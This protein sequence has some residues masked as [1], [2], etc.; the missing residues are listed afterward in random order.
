MITFWL[1]KD[2]NT[3]IDTNDPAEQVDRSK[4]LYETY[5]KLSLVNI[6]VSETCSQHRTQTWEEDVHEKA[7]VGRYITQCG[8]I[9]H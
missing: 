9:C 3:P 6:F 4:E 7:N 8:N 2:Q 1:T 5:G